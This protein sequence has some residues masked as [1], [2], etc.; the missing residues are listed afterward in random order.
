M[1]K[2][3]RTTVA[4]AAASEHAGP[5]ASS[6]LGRVWVGPLSSKLSRP[7]PEV[8]APTP[9]CASSALARG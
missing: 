3:F 4:A 1:T 6:S 8:W 2:S 5:I 9:R 7:K